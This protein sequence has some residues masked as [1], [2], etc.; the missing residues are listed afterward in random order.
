MSARRLGYAL[1]WSACALAVGW[2]PLM[3]LVTYAEPQRD[4]LFAWTAG[5]IG[6]PLLW[7]VGWALRYVLA[8][9]KRDIGF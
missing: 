5:L 2:L 3:L 8:G 1:Y 7:I 6:A 4:W 9:H